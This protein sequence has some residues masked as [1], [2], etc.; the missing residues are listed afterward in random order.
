MILALAIAVGSRT[1]V[2]AVLVLVAV[3][4]VVAVVNTRGPR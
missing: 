2:E 1:L 3:G 4:I